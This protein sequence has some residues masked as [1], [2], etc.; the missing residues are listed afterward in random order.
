MASNIGRQFKV[1]KDGKLVKKVGKKS[2]SQRIKER[3]S[4]K[5]K[6]VRGVR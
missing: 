1:T 3:K 6:F 4:P 2:V 5:R